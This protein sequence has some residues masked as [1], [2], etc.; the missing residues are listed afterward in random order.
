[1]T[2]DDPTSRAGAPGSVSG[3]I[4][5]LKD[6]DRRAMQALWERY[7][8]PL[9]RVARARLLPDRCRAAG[10][11]DVA[12]DALLEFCDHLARPDA[13]HRFPRLQG[14]EQ[15]WKLLVC[16][17]LRAA[18]DVSRKQ[19]RLAA[20]VR[21][22]SAL[23]E[24]G[25]AVFAGREPAPEFAAAVTELLDQLGEA[26]R[27]VALR[28]LEGFTVPEIARELDCSPSSVERKLRAIRAIWKSREADAP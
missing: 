25:F 10:A 7:F 28:K 24:D 21:G 26:L 1:M 13:D 15:V 4:P 19:A 8:R 6:G 5:G 18:F 23:G 12:L 22:E 9:V 11:E 17:T 14:R 27:T 16:F 2:R 20:V 3:L